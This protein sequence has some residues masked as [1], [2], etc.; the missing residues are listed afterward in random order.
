MDQTGCASRMESH[1][2]A[3]DAPWAC[4]GV[5]SLN[6]FEPISCRRPALSRRSRIPTRARIAV[7]AWLSASFRP[8][9]TSRSGDGVHP[10][11]HA[12][13]IRSAFAAYVF[14]PLRSSRS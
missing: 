6:L 12:T 1:R 8:Q 4:A 11:A 7:V 3:I 14:A 9:G 13:D 10:A 2:H 5:P